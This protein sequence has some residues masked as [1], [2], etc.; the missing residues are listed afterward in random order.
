MIESAILYQYI[1]S[2]NLMCN[3]ISVTLCASNAY[4]YYL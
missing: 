4:Y 1:Y 3:T 2:N